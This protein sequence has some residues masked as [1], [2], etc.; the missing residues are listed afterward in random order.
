MAQAGMHALVAAAVRK[1]T[2]KKEWLILGIFLGSIFPDLDNYAVAIAT[3]AKLNRESLHRTFTHSVFTILAAMLVFFLVALVR[4]Q[5]KWTNLG[6]GMG[7]GIGLHILLDLLIWFNGVELLWPLGGWVNFWEGFAAPGWFTKFM[8][9]AEFLFLALYFAWLANFAR[10]HKTDAD[11]MKTLRGWMIA[12]VLLM[13]VFTPL[14]Y[15]MQ[16]GFLT[17]FGA[18]Y[19]ISVT[20]AFIITIRMRQTVEAT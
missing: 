13:I 14:A 18:F 15:I 3:I 10:T 11:F 4:K 9:P 19:L 12:M 6:V 17:I 5:P 7:V 20:A 2:P 1:F 16:K 8:D